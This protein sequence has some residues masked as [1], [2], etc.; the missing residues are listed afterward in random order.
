MGI[1]IFAIFASVV[2]VLLFNWFK[3]ISIVSY[4]YRKHPFLSFFLLIL[5]MVFI[6]KLKLDSDGTKIGLFA[7]LP[8][9]FAAPFFVKGV[10]N[11]IEEQSLSLNSDQVKIQFRSWILLDM[12]SALSVFVVA[13]MSKNFH[14]LFK[15]DLLP[16]L[17][18]LLLA[19]AVYRISKALTRQLDEQAA[20]DR[21]KRTR[22][23]I[24]LAFCYFLVLI[25]TLVNMAF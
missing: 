1:L 23:K 25:F 24:N 13:L 16:I 5:L 2:I 7:F 12:C 22:M 4:L 8:L 9:F 19:A 10:T 6:F 3:N 14:S 18:S 20:D 17:G 15:G 21:L 11:L